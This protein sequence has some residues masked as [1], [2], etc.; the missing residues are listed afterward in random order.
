MAAEVWTLSG[1]KLTV[2]AQADNVVENLRDAGITGTN[3][4]GVITLTNSTLRS[5]NGTLKILE[6]LVRIASSTGCKI[7]YTNGS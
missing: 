2:T 7:N 5:T 3:S 1:G 4:A 6:E